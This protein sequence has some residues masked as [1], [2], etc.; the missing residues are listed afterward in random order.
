MDEITD[1]GRPGASQYF[2]KCV[3]TILNWKV[4]TGFSEAN[5]MLGYREPRVTG[6]SQL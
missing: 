4:N 2:K 6:R 5:P 1:S 3:V